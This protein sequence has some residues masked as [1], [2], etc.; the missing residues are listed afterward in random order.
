MSPRSPLRGAVPPAPAI[1]LTCF[2]HVWRR[3]HGSPGWRSRASSRGSRSRCRAPARHRRL[4]CGGGGG[5][6]A[7]FGCSCCSRG[8]A[9]FAPSNGPKPASFSFVSGDSF[10]RH[11][12]TL[13]NG[14][15]RLGVR[16]LGFTFRNADRGAG[17]TGRRAS[18]CDPRV[19]PAPQ[20][21][22]RRAPAQGF[23]ALHR[24]PLLPSGPR[25][26][27]RHAPLKIIRLA[28]AQKETFA[29]VQG[30]FSSKGAGVLL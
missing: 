10:A 7:A 25:F 14:S 20:P 19:L 22:P 12:A 24:A 8:H 1:E 13:A 2:L 15:F 5:H 23:R 4:C 17:C 28:H 29:G 3:P 18:A 21:A 27:V 11:P 9:R 26:E 30:L 16:L 6:L